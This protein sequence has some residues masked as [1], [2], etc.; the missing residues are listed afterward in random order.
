[1]PTKCFHDELDNLVFQ[2]PNYVCYPF[3]TN[4]HKENPKNKLSFH[5]NNITK[6]L[7]KLYKLVRKNHLC[8]HPKE[9]NFATTFFLRI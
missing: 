5:Q 2:I 4:A 8:S 9:Y 6:Q 1:M 7:S 3:A